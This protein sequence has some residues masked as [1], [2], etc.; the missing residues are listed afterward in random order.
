MPIK[1]SQDLA[2]FVKSHIW[3]GNTKKLQHTMASPATSSFLG[4]YQIMYIGR[5]FQI[6]L[7]WA[8][9]FLSNSWPNHI[10]ALI[11]PMIIFLSSVILIPAWCEWI[12]ICCKQQWICPFS[13]R[14]EAHGKN[15]AIKKLHY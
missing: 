4:S 5:F 8:F 12:C 2:T 7:F 6:F 14:F 3:Y 15:F 1:W 11:H 9:F 10:S 13:S